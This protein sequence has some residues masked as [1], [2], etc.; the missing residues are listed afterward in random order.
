M[1]ITTRFEAK[2]NRSPGL[3]PNGDCHEWTASLSRGYGQ[4]SFLGT[5]VKSHRVAWFLATGEWPELSVL[6]RCDNPPCVR[7]EHLFLGTQADNMHDMHNKGRNRSGR[8]TPEQ[9]AEIRNLKGIVSQRVLAERYGI[10][11]PT[12]SDIWRGRSWGKFVAESSEA[13]HAR[14]KELAALLDKRGVQ[15]CHKRAEAL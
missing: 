8:L 2:V 13:A 5:M 15:V 9:A 10:A 4:F 11:Q 3:G 7:F 1:R 6:H 12:V 14:V